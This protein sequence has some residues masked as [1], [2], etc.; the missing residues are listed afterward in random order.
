M[1][2]NVRK[3]VLSILNKNNYGYISPD[4][5]NM[6]ARVAQ[7]EVF[8]NYMYEYNHLNNKMNARQ[9][10]SD[11]ADVREL[12]Q[13]VIED[14]TQSTIMTTDG[15]NTFNLPSLVETGDVIFKIISVDARIETGTAGVFVYQATFQKVTQS[16]Y[17]RMSVSN[18]MSAAS[19]NPLYVKSGSQ[20]I[21]YGDSY[22]GNEVVIDYIRY[23]HPP[24]WTYLTIGGGEPMFDESSSSYQDF[25]VAPSEETELINKILQMAGMSIREIQAVQAAGLEETERKT[26][27]K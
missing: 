18:L 7:L 17:N 16:Q 5:F 1:I 4:D 25:E 2:N 27:Q 14:F 20:I 22:S 9:V 19:Y 10:G 23:P 15:N 8:E 6:Y 13:Q 11:S 3:T 21:C 26:E 12:K 24:Q